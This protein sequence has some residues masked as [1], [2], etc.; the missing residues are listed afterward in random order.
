[1]ENQIK[2]GETGGESLHFLNHYTKGDRIKRIA[3]V[4]FK[5]YGA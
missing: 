1:M 4:K 5:I 3:P 2:A